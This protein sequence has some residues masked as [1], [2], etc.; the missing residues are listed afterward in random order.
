[1]QSSA[2]L[3]LMVELHARA[4]ENADAAAEGRPTVLTPYKVAGPIR[5]E[6]IAGP[7]LLEDHQAARLQETSR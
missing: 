2:R 3:D 7:A 4:R 5:L 6:H 1:M